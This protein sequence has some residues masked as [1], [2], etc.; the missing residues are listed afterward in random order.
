MSDNPEKPQCKLVLKFKEDNST[1]K[2]SKENIP[3]KIFFNLEN[4]TITVEWLP[5]HNVQG[6]PTGPR[7]TTGSRCIT[8]L[9][10]AK[11]F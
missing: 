5:M 4:K 6:T 10:M 3:K 11:I 7:V 1:G 2:N 8:G 9:K